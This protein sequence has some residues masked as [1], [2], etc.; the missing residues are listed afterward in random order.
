MAAWEMAAFKQALKKKDYSTFEKMLVAKELTLSE[1][2]QYTDDWPIHSPTLNQIT[3]YL[4]YCTR[5]PHKMAWRD[6][7]YEIV[8][9]LLNRKGTAHDSEPEGAV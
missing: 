4:A 3:G 2:F 7:V 6:F 1:Y 9:T 8:G 5:T